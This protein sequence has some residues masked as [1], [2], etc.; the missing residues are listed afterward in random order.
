MNQK[1]YKVY[2]HKN[3][4]NQKY[5]IGLTSYFNVNKRWRNGNGYNGQIFGEAIK[6]YGWENFDH[7]VVAEN[8]TK[9]EAEELEKELIKKY[10]SKVPNGYNIENGG[11]TN[12]KQ[13]EIICIENLEIYDDIYDVLSKN[14]KIFKGKISYEDIKDCCEFE[15]PYIKIPRKNMY[16]HF[17][18]YTKNTIYDISEI[19]NICRNKIKNRKNRSCAILKPYC[20]RGIYDDYITFD[21]GR[22]IRNGYKMCIQCGRLYKKQDRFHKNLCERCR[23]RGIFFD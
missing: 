18:Y 22:Y 6:K 15:F 17:Q 11:Q 1:K 10:N 23:Q 5:Y 19:E 21:D 16:L 3:L 2:Y 12:Y 14:Y 8:L 9:T 20:E 4:I 13:G 7:C